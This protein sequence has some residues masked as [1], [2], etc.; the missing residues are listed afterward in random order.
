MSFLGN[1]KKKQRGQTIFNFL[2]VI[3]NPI[4]LVI[5]IIGNPSTIEYLSSDKPSSYFRTSYNLMMS[6]A[7]PRWSLYHR[8]N[9]N[10]FIVRLSPESY[11]ISLNNLP[12]EFASHLA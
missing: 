1:K 2:S 4:R 6:N 3:E 5:M 12:L 8:C 10:C 11:P 7:F 9:T